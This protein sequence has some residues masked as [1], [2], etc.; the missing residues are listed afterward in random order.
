MLTDS[1]GLIDWV[2]LSARAKQKL[3]DVMCVMATGSFIPSKELE[4]GAL[5]GWQA[6]YAMARLVAEGWSI[7]IGSGRDNQRL[8]TRLTFQY[9]HRKIV[10][11]NQM[12]ERDLMGDLLALARLGVTPTEAHIYEDKEVLY[13]LPFSVVF[14]GNHNVFVEARKLPIVVEDR[15]KEKVLA[16][17]NRVWIDQGIL[18]ELLD[19][20]NTVDLRD[21]TKGAER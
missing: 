20:A 19:G 16:D 1:K 14:N 18:N 15:M 17:G 11:T 4:E 12:L 3:E 9:D 8:A 7:Y 13:R 10:L 2:G 5:R 6:E 21:M